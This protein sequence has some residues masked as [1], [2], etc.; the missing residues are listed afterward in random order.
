K[1]L[2]LSEERLYG[3]M[4]AGHSLVIGAFWLGWTGQYANIPWYVPATSTAF[5][6]AGI[7]LVFVSFPSYLVDTYLM[8]AKSAF[9]VNT[10]TDIRSL[11]ATALPLFTVQIYHNLGVDWASTLVRLIALVHAPNPFL[12]YKFG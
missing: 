11:V 2:S 3:A 6:G 4:I 12:F 8:Y 1:G 10:D 9:A 7:N 5:V